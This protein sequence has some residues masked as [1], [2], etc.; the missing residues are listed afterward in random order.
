MK[1]S[2]DQVSDMFPNELIK[3]SFFQNIMSQTLR[4]PQVGT[5]SNPL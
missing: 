5:S 2:Q 4:V 1:A 3:R